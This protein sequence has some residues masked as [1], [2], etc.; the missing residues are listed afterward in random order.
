M[1]EK[2][3]SL[4]EFVGQGMYSC[5]TSILFS[6]IATSLLEQGDGISPNDVLVPTDRRVYKAV[7]TCSAHDIALI[8]LAIL[9]ILL[10]LNRALSLRP[11]MP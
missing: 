3:I 1:K 9:T 2:F 11:E 5:I 4:T 7:A 8:D 6:G 10:S